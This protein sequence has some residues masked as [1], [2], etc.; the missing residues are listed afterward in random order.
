MM[1]LHLIVVAG[2][3]AANLALAQARETRPSADCELA[4]ESLRAREAAVLAARR[5]AEQ[6]GDRYRLAPDTQLENLR[7]R[8]A[9]ACVGGLGDAPPSGRLAQPPVDVAPIA[10]PQP[11][12]R[13]VLPAAPVAPPLKQTAPPV[14]IT[15]CDPTGCW[16][17]D[18][19]RLP[20]MGTNLLGPRGLCSVQG[21]LL[22]CP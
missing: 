10:L 1:H 12:P 17:S 22:N 11:A 9:R 2:A 4:L 21:T 8:A 19:S 6:P 14:T 18:G 7:R 5:A 15:A 16:A 20:R 13:R 3:L